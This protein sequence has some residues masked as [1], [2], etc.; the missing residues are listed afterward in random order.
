[1]NRQQCGLLTFVQRP[2]TTTEQLDELEK[3]LRVMV[4]VGM[5]AA[6]ERVFRRKLLEALRQNGGDISTVSN[7]LML[8]GSRAFGEKFP[9]S[10]V[11][12]E[13]VIIVHDEQS[14]HASSEAV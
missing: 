11:H 14:V 7:S 12:H 4:E 13:C 1:M 3:Y 8:R 2:A 5:L 10:T 6:A 9:I